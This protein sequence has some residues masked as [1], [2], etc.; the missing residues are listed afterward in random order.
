MW[1][2]I[3]VM[4]QVDIDCENSSKETPLYVACLF[5]HLQCVDFLLKNKIKMANV[6]HTTLLEETPLH[7]GV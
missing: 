7:A 6:N 3:C 2:V 1:S 4:L 5:G